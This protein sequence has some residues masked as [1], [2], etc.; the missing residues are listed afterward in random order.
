MNCGETLKTNRSH[1]TC[2]QGTEW[3]GDTGACVT[4]RHVATWHVPSTA[5]TYNV[6][7]RDWSGRGKTSVSGNCL[8]RSAAETIP[9]H[10]NLA[11]NIFEPIVKY[12]FSA[13]ALAE[14]SGHWR[15]RVNDPHCAGVL[16]HILIITNVDVDVGQNST[17]TNNRAS[18]AHTQPPPFINNNVAA[19]PS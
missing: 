7:R 6:S 16:M 17:N 14:T 11:Q 13:G 3:S 4:S 2:E 9:R 12:F 8:P 15:C 1:G 10:N 18:W 19:T 5:A